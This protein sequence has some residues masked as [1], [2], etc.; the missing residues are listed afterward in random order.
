MEQLV[1]NQRNVYD[2]I[3]T[4]YDNRT[5]RQMINHYFCLKNIS[6]SQ[7]CGRAGIDRRLVSKFVSDENYHPSKESCLAVC[8]GFGLNT[9][10]A[11]DLL[12][13]CGYSFANNSSRDL[14]IAYALK[15]GVHHISDLNL[16][17]R[18]LG[19]KQFKEA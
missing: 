11:R 2:F 16:L 12:R 4:H 6:T 15:I 14:A 5:F 7:L 19:E 9:E 13:I 3:H 17:L 10:E 18:E 1:M 8:V